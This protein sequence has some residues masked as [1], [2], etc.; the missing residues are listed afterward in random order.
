MVLY[1]GKLQPSYSNA[2]TYCKY[3]NNYQFQVSIIH[4][5]FRYLHRNAL[6]IVMRKFEIQNLSV[7][8]SVWGIH[9]WCQQAKPTQRKFYEYENVWK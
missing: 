6:F 8:Y 5:K 3:K 7:Y 1:S 4:I 9:Y 2:G